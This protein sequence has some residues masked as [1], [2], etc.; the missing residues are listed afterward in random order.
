MNPEKEERQDVADSLEKTRRVRLEKQDKSVWLTEDEY[1]DWS[2]RE[3]ILQSAVGR[4]SR[5]LAFLV[6]FLLA[7]LLFV[8]F[9]YLINH[10]KKTADVAAPVAD[11]ASDEPPVDK[12]PESSTPIQ[13]DSAGA[14]SDQTM[15]DE[16]LATQSEATPV[17]DEDAETVAQ[18]AELP[19]DASE[20]EFELE[21]NDLPEPIDKLATENSAPDLEAEL[22][23]ERAREELAQID[24]VFIKIKE[25][26]PREAD[27]AIAE[28]DASIEQANRFVQTAPSELA[29]PGDAL[30]DQMEAFRDALQKNLDFYH[31][32]NA[33]DSASL[34]A[35][36][37]RAFYDALESLAD[38]SDDESADVGAALSPG[39]YREEL[40]RSAETLDAL[41]VVERWNEFMRNFGKRLE[42]FRCSPQDAR[43]GLNF[44]A[45]MEGKP[46]AP[47]EL[48]IVE[49]R[50]PQWRFDAEHDFPTQRKIL[51]MLE[52]ELRQQYWTYAPSRDVVYYL[53]RAPRVGVNDYVA[54]AAGTLAKVEIPS[55]APELETTVSPQK[56]FLEDLRDRARQIPDALRAE[57]VGAWYANWAAFLQTIQDA[58]ALDPILQYKFLQ[59]TARCLQSSDFYFASRLEPL[60]RVLNAP[61]LDED[62]SVDRFQTESQKIKSLRAL[63][64]AR[65]SF[66][67]K[68]HL[69]V[70]K[71]TKQLDAAT[72]RFATL[73]QRIGWL[74][75]NF[76]G[77]WRLRRPDDAETPAG[78]LYA[79][80]VETRGSDPRWLKIGS[81][82]GRQIT[83]N[84]VSSAASRGIVVLCRVPEE[85]KSSTVSRSDV[86]QLFNR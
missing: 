79:L 43:L 57:D 82:N 62:A 20:P 61:Q 24:A 68:D 58:D 63:A 60:L 36:E 49:K 15:S 19:E 45:E 47:E 78:E 37:T 17:E 16:I 50:A 14:R 25:Y 21:E 34:D 77:E 71:T 42:R 22:K 86:N 41:D 46:G 84:F 35:A 73:Y 59:K 9:G 69:K 44:I 2:K 5:I 29:E 85:S 53:P 38:P 31:R 18:N 81:S 33:L 65:V 23:R 76:N 39:A 26:G 56:R 83:I 6:P 4:K 8:F 11:A 51:L 74:D 75:R 52:S 13:N 55:D 1:V 70:D 80:C 3:Q 40:A 27:S 12:V 54:D 7:F 28:L 48:E 66:L 10:D 67:P 72:E 30:R 32:L 64:A